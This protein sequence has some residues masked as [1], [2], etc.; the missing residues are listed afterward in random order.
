LQVLKYMPC[1]VEV[2]NAIQVSNAAEEGRGA[3]IENGFVID[4][5]PNDSGV[6]EQRAEDAKEVNKQ[7]GEITE[8]EKP[9]G[10]Q[11]GD[12]FEVNMD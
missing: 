5:E 9:S 7:T 2:S 8:K 1:S 6:H 10:E 11:Q 12:D 4:L 3:T